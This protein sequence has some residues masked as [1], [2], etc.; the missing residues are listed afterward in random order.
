MWYYVSCANTECDNNVGWRRK[1]TGTMK[2]WC[3]MAVETMFS[4]KHAIH[5]YERGSS[6][7]ITS[8]VGS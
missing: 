1:P 7:I 6:V 3:L 2:L 5:T 4:W 8:M